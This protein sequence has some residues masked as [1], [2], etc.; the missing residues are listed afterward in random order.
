MRATWL[1]LALAACGGGLD[2][3]GGPDAPPDIDAAVD[4][5]TGT[6]RVTEGITGLW[7]FDD[8][9]GAGG[10]TISDS[11]G[12]LEPVIPT[13]DNP[14]GVTWLATS[15]RVNTPIVISTPPDRLPLVDA[16]RATNEA[17]LE[18]WVTATTDTQTGTNGQP[19]RIASL[20]P[21]NAGNHSISLGQINGDWVAQARTS[22]TDNNGDP[23]LRQP[24]V[25]GK[26]MHLVIT[27]NATSRKFYV[28]GVVVEDTLGGTLN[29]PST[30]IS[31][32][33]ASEPN[34]NNPLNE[35]VGTFHV[36]A[37]YSQALDAD[38]VMRNFMAGPTF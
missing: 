30:G 33:L 25:I 10:A 23:V 9:G 19:A 12:V 20:A 5:D 26:S 14:A 2:N 32:A 28:D 22:Q 16:A 36:V 38:E 24:I 4:G 29:W 3:T 11:S 6:G 1:S 27:V 34:P 17:T 7:E 21:Q 37:M 13:I 35:W 15:L 8:M 18:A 31:F